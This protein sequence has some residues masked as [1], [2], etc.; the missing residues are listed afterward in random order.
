MLRFGVGARI[1]LSEYCERDGVDLATALFSESGARA[2]V[3]VDE[4]DSLGLEGLAAKHDVQALRIGT[5]GGDALSIIGVGNLELTELK[6]ASD[7]T[8]RHYF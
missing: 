1:D 7:A 4:Q 8:L 6:A 5:T 3:A 2:L